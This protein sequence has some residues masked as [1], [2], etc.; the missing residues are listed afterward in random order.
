MAV[1]RK[2]VFLKGREDRDL[3]CS[4]GKQGLESGVVSAVLVRIAD[5]WGRP[6]WNR[7]STNV[8]EDKTGVESLPISKSKRNLG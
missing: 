3:D 8:Q 1:R 4:A 6:R 2:T 7:G 5:L